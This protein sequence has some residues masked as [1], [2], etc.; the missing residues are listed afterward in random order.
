MGEG[1]TGSVGD[2][3][4]ALTHGRSALLCSALLSQALAPGSNVRGCRQRQ[5]PEPTLSPTHPVPCAYIYVC[6]YVGIH[7]YISMY[8]CVCIY[9]YI[10]I[11]MFIYIYV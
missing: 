1:G 10:Y 4:D 5:V 9:I 2:S 3:I 11:H 6:I 8:I 7:V